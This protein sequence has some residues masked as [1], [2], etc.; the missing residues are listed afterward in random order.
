MRIA[1]AHHRHMVGQGLAPIGAAGRGTPMNRLALVLPLI[2]LAA[3]GNDPEVKMENASVGEVA[4]EMRKQAGTSGSFITPGKWQQTV[5]LLE[6][7][8]PGMPPEAK[9]IMQKAMG[10]LQQVEHC[11]TAEQAKRPPEDFFAKANDC[12]YDHFNW[13]G[14]KIDLKLTCTVP[15]GSMTMVQTGE[16]QPGGYSMAVTQTIGNAASAQPMVMKMS[17]DARRVGDCDGNEKVQVGS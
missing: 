5:K 10:E 7:E 13:G 8:A 12:R 6:I 4:Q 9:E 16:Y 1:N 14:G 3:C 15:Q 11:L 2:S 17:V